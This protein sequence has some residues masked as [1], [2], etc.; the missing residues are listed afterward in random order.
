M[1]E[2]S[3]VTVNAIGIPAVV[4]GG[5][6]T[7]KCVAVPGPVVPMPVYAPALV[8]WVGGSGFGF[9]AS[10]GV[11]GGIGWFPL[12]PREI[13]LPSYRVSERYVT[14]VNVTNTVV[15]RVTVVNV[16]KSQNIQN[17]T[18]V[19]RVAPNAVTIVSRENF[20]SARPVAGNMVNLPARELA[21]APVSHI[22]SIEPERSSI[23]GAGSRN[24]PHPPAQVMNRLVIAKQNP[25]PEPNHFGRVQ[26]VPAGQPPSGSPASGQQSGGTRPPQA[27][28]APENQQ[29]RQG[30]KPLDAAADKPPQTPRPLTKPAPTVRPPTS[31]EQSDMKAKQKAWENAHA[32]SKPKSESKDQ[33]SP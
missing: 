6:V 4:L 24:V 12:G 23:Y 1:L 33:K 11:G 8:A 26:S 22:S 30:A 10:F 29:M 14:D 3:A 7:E 13:F 28:P 19:N 15:N 16:Y 9:S 32:R 31:K 27:R 17:A 5:A 21:S 20:V 25:P 2:S 18:Y